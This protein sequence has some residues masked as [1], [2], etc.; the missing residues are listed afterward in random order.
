MSDN[1]R[2]ARCPHCNGPAEFID[3]KPCY[4][5]GNCLR[6]GAT[7]IRCAHCGAQPF[8][9]YASTPEVARQYLAER[10]NRRGCLENRS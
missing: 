3:H 1:L 5:E 6:D 2:L 10:W 9:A 7:T 8:V 4:E